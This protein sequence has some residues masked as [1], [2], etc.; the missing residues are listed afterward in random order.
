ML[1]SCALQCC[2]RSGAYFYKGLDDMNLSRK[3]LAGAILALLPLSGALACTTAAWSAVAGAPIA[4]DPGTN[5]AN[6]NNP[7]QGNVP[8]YSGNCALL[9]ASAGN[10]FVTNNTPGNEG[11]YRARFYLLTGA[12]AGT[13]RV[14]RATSADDGGGTEIFS[15]TYDPANSELD[16]AAAGTT[17]PS[18][19]GIVANRWYSI[20]VLH[21]TG[22]TLSVTV[23]GNNSSPTNI[24]GTPTVVTSAAPVVGAVES[25]QLGITNAGAVTGQIVVDEFDSTRSAATPIG[26]LRRGD[27]NNSCASSSTGI[28][29]ADA[30]LARNEFLSNSGSLAIGNP[31]ANES[32]GITIADAT[33]IR[34][35][36]LT[37]NTSCN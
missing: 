25:A 29:I 37:S 30:V 14:F 19:T 6:N 16:F 3:F 18:V 9:A 13:P 34:N 27:A 32:G 24:A 21:Q 23:N 28:S 17:V 35:M 22:Q 4:D 11:I 36:F 20:E 10:S 31:D 2:C 26:R 12:T 15:V 8:R 5:N 7:D 1:V 33:I